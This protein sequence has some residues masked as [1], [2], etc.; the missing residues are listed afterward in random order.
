ME[1]IML[2]ELQKSKIPNLFQMFDA[3][4]NGVLDK[5]DIVRIVNKCAIQ[6]NLDKSSEAYNQH[7]S[8]FLGLWVGMT[9]LADKD[10]DDKV[11]LEEFLAFFDY[12]IESQNNYKGLVN[13]ISEGFF[14]T[15]DQD[16]DGALTFIEYRHFY[17]AMGLDERYARDIFR[18]LD[19]DSNGKIAIK[20]LKILID[21][22]FRSQD[23]K[24]P[25]N[26][27]FGP[28]KYVSA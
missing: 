17:E 23:E 9:S 7:E 14:C 4:Q 20:T 3:N 18:Q 11:T 19:L 26:Q 22:F 24:A 2:S 16:N 27:F 25:G 15:F 13:G 12:L 28:I 21:Q 8:A 1:K 5:E 10:L 6:K